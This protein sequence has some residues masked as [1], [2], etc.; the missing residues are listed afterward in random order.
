[1][2]VQLRIITRDGELVFVQD[3][4]NEFR[5]CEAMSDVTGADIFAQVIVDGLIYAEEAR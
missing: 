1:M 3:F 4:D 5:A 2:D